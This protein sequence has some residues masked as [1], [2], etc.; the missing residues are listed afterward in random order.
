MFLL[1]S[2]S[3]LFKRNSD[4]VLQKAQRAFDDLNV[5][6]LQLDQ[7][8]NSDAIAL[9][10]KPTSANWSDFVFLLETTITRI[11]RETDSP[12]QASVYV[13]GG[14]DLTVLFETDKETMDLVLDFIEEHG[15]RGQY[16][17]WIGIKTGLFKESTPAKPPYRY[18]HQ[19]TAEAL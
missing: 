3:R 15:I 12:T 16:N 8:E 5:D 14:K 11:R 17:D 19:P 1:L 9:R 7:N 10:I 13:T 18:G 6:I 2:L 4:P